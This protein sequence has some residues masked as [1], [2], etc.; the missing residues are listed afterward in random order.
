[1]ITYIPKVPDHSKALLDSVPSSILQHREMEMC[2]EGNKE[3]GKL[4]MLES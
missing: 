3:H 4:K 1:M 2:N